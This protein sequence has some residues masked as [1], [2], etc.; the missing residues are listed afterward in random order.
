MSS[1]CGTPPL[2]E[3][4]GIEMQSSGNG[5]TTNSQK[6]VEFRYEGRVYKES[7]RDENQN[8]A[9]VGKKRKRVTIPDAVYESATTMTRAIKQ[10]TRFFRCL[11]CPL[12]LFLLMI[13]LI[14]AAGLVLVVL[15]ASGKSWILNLPTADGKMNIRYVPDLKCASRIN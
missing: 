11:M 10:Q 14:A 5:S 6:P 9:K 8:M 7:I 15:M 13:F 4:E 2:P 12:T 3:G 1:V